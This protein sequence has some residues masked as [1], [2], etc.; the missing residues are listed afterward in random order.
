[1]FDDKVHGRTHVGANKQTKTKSPKCRHN[2]LKFGFPVE[3]NT[4]FSA[5]NTHIVFYARKTKISLFKSTNITFSGDWPENSIYVMQIMC[6]F[7]RMFFVPEILQRKFRLPCGFIFNWCPPMKRW[8]FVDTHGAEMVSVVECVRVWISFHL[9]LPCG[10]SW[11][12][13]RIHLVCIGIELNDSLEWGR[14]SIL[15][16]CC[17]SSIWIG[18]FNA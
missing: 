9:I 18:H 13:H 8:P 15:F 4:T 6:S 11:L 10:K 5:R 16:Q 12:I 7:D 3:P 1:M 17:F 2:K 14:C